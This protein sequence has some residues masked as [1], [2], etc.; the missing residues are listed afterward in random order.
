M[1][2]SSGEWCAQFT[3]FFH[4]KTLFINLFSLSTAFILSILLIIVF[5]MINQKF[6]LLPKNFCQKINF[7]LQI[8]VLRISSFI[9][10]FLWPSISSLFIG[11]FIWNILITF[12]KNQLIPAFL[13]RDFH[14]IKNGLIHPFLLSII[15]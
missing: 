8:G 10:F 9:L 13:Q 2:D 12:S 11:Q 1:I 3:M 14:I 4:S 6:G 15:L 7:F 5:V